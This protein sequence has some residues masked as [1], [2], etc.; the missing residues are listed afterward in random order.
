[1]HLDNIIEIIHTKTG[2]DAATIG[3]YSYK[4]AI[5]KGMKKHGFNLP[6]EYID[7]QSNP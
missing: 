5:K 1:M 3:D 6:A 2:I 4:R 7:A